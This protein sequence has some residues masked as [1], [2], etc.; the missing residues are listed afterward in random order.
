MCDRMALNGEAL[1]LTEERRAEVIDAYRQLAARGER[2]L[3]FALRP[4]ESRY[5]ARGRTTSFLV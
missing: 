3:G 4:A 1:P 2:G 5:S